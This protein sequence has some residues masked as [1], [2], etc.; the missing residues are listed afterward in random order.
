MVAKIQSS[1][2]EFDTTPAALQKLKLAGVPDKVILAMVTAPSVSA[3]PPLRAKA[4]EIVEVK[5]PGNTPIDVELSYVISSD[6]RRGRP[7]RA[8]ESGARRGRRR[9]NFSRTGAEAQG[10]SPPSSNRVS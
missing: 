9:C 10:E 2:C 4:P 7:C 3:P 8:D 1:P 6:D 5:I